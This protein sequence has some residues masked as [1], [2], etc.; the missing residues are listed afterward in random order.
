MNDME[1]VLR[2]DLERLIERLSMSVPEGAVAAG[3]EGRV[4]A[5]EQRLASAYTALVEDYGRWNLAL[6]D[7]ENI[8]AL[9]IWRAAFAEEPVEGPVRRAA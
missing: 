3:L 1:R 4:D 7:L 2:S 9:A 8:W 6:D 5:A